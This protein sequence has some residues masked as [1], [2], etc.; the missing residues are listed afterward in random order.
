MPFFFASF[1]F[2]HPP[3]HYGRFEIGARARSMHHAEQQFRRKVAACFKKQ[4]PE[5]RPIVVF[6]LDVVELDHL[7][8]AV[9][10][11]F[12]SVHEDGPAPDP[13]GE[14]EG[15]YRLPGIKNSEYSSGSVFFS[16]LP[17]RE[18][19]ARHWSISMPQDPERFMLID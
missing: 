1:R 11:N 15:V 7:S 13:A 9:L 2:E 12:S 18:P 6:L 3:A 17:L 14:A 19:N 16:G 4:P 8:E 5:Q 10:M